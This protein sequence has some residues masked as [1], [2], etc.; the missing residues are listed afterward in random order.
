M[1]SSDETA[2]EF[3]LWL[4]EV[5]YLGS[6]IGSSKRKKYRQVDGLLIFKSLILEDINTLVSFGGDPLKY[7]KI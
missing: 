3:K 7:L 5:T 1:G 4:D 2:D 6:L